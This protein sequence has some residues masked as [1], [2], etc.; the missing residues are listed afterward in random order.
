MRGTPVGRQFAS[1]SSPALRALNSFS[2]PGSRINLSPGLSAREMSP[3]KL[4]SGR[5]TP[6]KSTRPLARRGAGPVTAGGRKPPRRAGACTLPPGGGRSDGL[7]VSAPGA[8]AAAGASS[9][10]TFTIAAAKVE[11]V[12][13][14]IE[15]D[16]LFVA[17][18][19]GPRALE[20]YINPIPDL[21]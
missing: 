7:R 18:P 6:D 9:S 19:P 21:R 14:F 13:S 1:G 4:L 10:T 8:C 15:T 3:T 20:D 11:P 17:Q 16:L 12:K 2:A 5:Q